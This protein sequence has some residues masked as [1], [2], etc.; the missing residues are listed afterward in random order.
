MQT[1]FMTKIFGSKYLLITFLKKFVRIL[2][3]LSQDYTGSDWM[4][5]VSNEYIHKCNKIATKFF[6]Y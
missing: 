2:T 1:T 5:D 6:D 3:L 4:G